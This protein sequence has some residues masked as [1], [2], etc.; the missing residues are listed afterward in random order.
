MRNYY[1]S[2]NYHRPYGYT[3]F[4]YNRYFHTP[5]YNPYFHTNHWYRSYDW[6]TYVY[7]YNRNYIYANWIFFPAS[8]YNNG[9]WTIDNYPYY[10]YN[11]Y[12]NRYS[13]VDQCN[14]QLVDENNHTVIQSFWNQTCNTGYDM[15]SVQRDRMN[16]QE[17]EYRYFCSETYRDQNYDYSTPS[18][19][20]SHYGSE[21]DEVSDESCSDSDEDGVCDET[22]EEL[23]G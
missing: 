18:Y 4:A 23:A 8:G 17:G 22:S 2:R 11:G 16:D 9:Y 14:Y 13:S 7:G 6:Y 15:C 5:F 10:V 20:E 21:D 1:G 3:R 19:D 12:R